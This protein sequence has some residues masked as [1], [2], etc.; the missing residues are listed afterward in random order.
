MG[1][2]NKNL[3]MKMIIMILNH[4]KMMIMIF[5]IRNGWNVIMNASCSSDTAITERKI[6]RQQDDISL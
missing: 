4:R 3:K 2:E 5:R 1:E 6:T